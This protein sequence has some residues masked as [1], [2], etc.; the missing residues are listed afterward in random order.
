MQ[1]IATKKTYSLEEYFALETALVETKHEFFNG[2]IFAMAGA[3]PNHN[4][5][6][7]N[8]I[9]ELRDAIKRSKKPCRVFNSDQRVRAEQPSAS[10]IGYF[11]PDVSVVC[12]KPKFSNDNPPTLLNPTLIIEVLSDSTREYDFGKKLDYYRAI[13]SV[14]EIVFVSFDKVGASRFHRQNDAW[15][16]RDVLGL[17]QMLTLESL[18]ISIPLT[19]LYRDVIFA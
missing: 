13:E 19:E 8:L 5:L 11:Y 2:E 3:H 7:V 14:Q 9:G 12:G 18:E 16:L 1:Q 15:I 4:T 6:C 17:E 10:R